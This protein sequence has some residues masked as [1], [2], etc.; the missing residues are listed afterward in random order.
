MVTADNL[1]LDVLETIFCYLS[2]NDLSS[3]ALVSRS[4]FSGVIPTL[5]ATLKFRRRQA[6]RYRDVSRVAF[7]LS[8]GVHTIRKIITPF[9]VVIAR[10]ELSPHVKHIGSSWRWLVI[11]FEGK[12][13]LILEPR[14]SYCSYSE[15]QH[16]RQVPD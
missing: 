8:S 7:M 9:A 5:Y 14:H 1:N 13:K 11:T 6:K 16:R 12:K 4:F 15:I 3:V 10:P 2:G